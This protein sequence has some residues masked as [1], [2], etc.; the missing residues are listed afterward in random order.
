MSTVPTN[1]LRVCDGGIAVFTGGA[2]GIGRALT[3]GLA[4]R[5]CEVVVAD[6]Q[7]DLAEEV[8][9]S[10][11]RREVGQSRQSSTSPT[12]RASSGCSRRR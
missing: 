11:E 12:S 3:E 4:N 5:G 10:I 2:S 9:G 8:A 7:I 1:V 6:L